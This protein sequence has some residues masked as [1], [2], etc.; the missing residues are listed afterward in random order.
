MGTSLLVAVVAKKDSYQDS[1]LLC[2]ADF[3]ALRDVS[4]LK[5]RTP[6]LEGA[7]GLTTY[8]IHRIR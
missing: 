8:Q 4:G 3:A 6:L 2:F 1:Y 5:V 7:R